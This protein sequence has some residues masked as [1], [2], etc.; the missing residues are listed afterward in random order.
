MRADIKERIEQIREGKIP[1]GYKKTKLGVVPTEWKKIEFRELFEE[2]KERTSDTTKYPLYSLTLED[3]IVEK[4]ERYDREHLVKKEDSAYKVVHPNEFAYN[5]MNIR[6]GAVAR[7]KSGKAVSVSGYY[8][9]FKTKNFKD[10]E[11]MEHFLVGNQMIHYYNTVCTGSLEEK[12]R[13]HFSDFILFELTLPTDKERERISK[14]LMTCDRKIELVRRQIQESIN[15]KKWT[16]QNFLAG[17]RRLRG[18]KSKWEKRKIGEFIYEIDDRTKTT[19]EYDIM[20][21]TKNGICLQNEHFNKQI[22]SQDNTGYKI[23]HRGN[24][25]FSTMN[26]WMGSLDVLDKYEKGIVSPAYKVFGFMSDKMISEF[27][28]YFMKSETMIWKYNIH[29]EQGASVVRR[30]L[31]ISGLL[32]SI[33]SIPSIEEQKALVAILQLMDQELELL[34]KKLELL[35]QEKKALMQ[36][37]LTGI[38]RVNEI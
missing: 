20:S 36:L 13:V 11:F 7:N 19:N 4:S 1:E 15:I 26:L 16:M 29:S 25:V 10:K 28:K 22:A 3:G 33:V 32:A 18:F 6:L 17:K 24:L 37:L 9:V 14:V 30:N 5:P 2:Q 23:V 21:V 31:D 8:D 38:V 12:K 34:N 35:K 27:G